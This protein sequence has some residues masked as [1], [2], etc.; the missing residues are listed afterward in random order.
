MLMVMDPIQQQ[1]TPPNPYGFIVNP[2]QPSKRPLFGGGST[3]S[4]LILVIGI[5]LIIMILGIIVSSIFSAM[6]SAGT[7]Q[8]KIVYA[9]QQEIIR[10]AGFGV[11]DAKGSDAR[12]FAATTL[13]TTQTSQQQISSALSKQGVKI[14]P[15]D[16][17]IKLNNKVEDI[18][19]GAAANN[20]YDETLRELLEKQI[21]SYTKALEAAHDANEGQ[22]I[23]TTLTDSYK[24]AAL[25]VV[26]PSDTAN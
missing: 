17:N 18:L 9:E 3:K 20:R 23:R 24:S 11:K 12:N 5:V 7:K 16:A 15:E 14:S 19:T 21:A 8:L 13:Y 6:G 25:L 22:Q 2:E 10:I 26:K 1:P 4:R